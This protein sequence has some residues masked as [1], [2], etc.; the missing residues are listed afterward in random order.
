[1]PDKII[2]AL[3]DSRTDAEGALRDLSGVGIGQ[4]RV[5]IATES[6]D[7]GTGGALGRTGNLATVLNDRTLPPEDRE[8]FAEGLR[9]GA[10]LLTARVNEAAAPEVVRILDH[11]NAV[12]LDDRANQW[13]TSGWAGPAVSGGTTETRAGGFSASGDMA[14]RVGRT[15]AQEGES[16]PV[17]QEELVVGKR[18]VAS[19]SVRVHSFVTE[20][21]VQ[22]QI[23]LREEHVSVERRPVEQGMKAGEDLLQERT[24][25]FTETSEEAVV[26]KTARVVEEVVVRKEVGERVETI[27]DT[28]R[29]TD[30]EI[31]DNR[32]G[33]RR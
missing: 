2:T 16:I 20:T 4:D 10:Y 24:V 15:E 8:T 27:E 5:Q 28:V 29:R 6:K 14:Q 9:R 1:V 11:S 17:I 23:A 19:G 21:P 3:F 33:T 12:D 30:V 31:E 22:E 13:R 26:A 25:E 32:G 18:E 7:L